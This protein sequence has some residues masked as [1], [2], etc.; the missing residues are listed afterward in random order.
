MLKHHTTWLLNHIWWAS[1]I[2]AIRRHRNRI[3]HWSGSSSLVQCHHNNR[4]LRCFL[5]Q[6]YSSS[7]SYSSSLFLN[8]HNLIGVNVY[9]WLS[10]VIITK[11]IC[12][13]SLLFS[14]FLSPS[15]ACYISFRKRAIPINENRRQLFTVIC[16]LVS[17]GNCGQSFNVERYYMS[18]HH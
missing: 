5:F 13:A 18:R 9:G 10:I 3:D 7:F 8:H 14:C 16:Q 17:I 6:I 4:L 12:R 15:S 1:I 2:V 11:V